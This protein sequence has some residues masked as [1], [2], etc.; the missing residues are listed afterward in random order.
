MKDYKKILKDYINKNIPITSKM[1]FK[2]ESYDKNK[3]VISALLNANK[4]DKN[5]AFA[6]S[7]YSLAVLTGW[8]LLKLKLLCENLNAD[9]AIHN[10]TIIYHKPVLNNFIAECSLTDNE[11]YDEFLTRLKEKSN[12][13]LSLSIKISEKNDPENTV[14]AELNGE[15]FSWIK[16]Q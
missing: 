5:S 11:N 14:K 9:T 2:I 13:K 8:G 10:A 3:L 7:I 15:Y 4:N 16:K 1:K 12:A 6:G